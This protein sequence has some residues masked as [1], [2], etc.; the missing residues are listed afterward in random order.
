M[1]DEITAAIVAG[2][3]AALR[4]RARVQREKARAAASAGEAYIANRLV[5]V[6][7]RI[8]DDIEAGR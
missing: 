5:D 6:L 4:K 2:A 3:V 8:A 1:D 7:S